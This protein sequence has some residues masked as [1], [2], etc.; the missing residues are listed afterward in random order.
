MAILHEM[1]CASMVQNPSEQGRYT[2][3]AEKKAQGLKPRFLLA[4]CGTAEEAAEK[5]AIG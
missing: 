1:H 4:L 5:L 3:L 2:Y